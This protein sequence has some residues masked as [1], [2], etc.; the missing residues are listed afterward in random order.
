[1]NAEYDNKKWKCSE[2]GTYYE[3]KED[4]EKCCKIY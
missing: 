2:C 3:D 4:A 1:M